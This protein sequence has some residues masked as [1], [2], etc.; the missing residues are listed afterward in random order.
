[1]G[2]NSQPFQRTLVVNSPCR[3]KVETER[4][5]WHSMCPTFVEDHDV[6][7]EGRRNLM[8]KCAHPACNCPAPQGEK[9]CGAYCHD[10]KDLTELACNCGHGDCAEEMAPPLD[11]R[12]VV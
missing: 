11:Q 4:S 1:M 9:Y 12:K 7:R 6:Q 5:E 2:P 3:L 10:A 8:D